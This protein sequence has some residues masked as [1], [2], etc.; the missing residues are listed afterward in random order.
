MANDAGS[1]NDRIRRLQQKITIQ[2]TEVQA[3][4]RALLE[5]LIEL[6]HERDPIR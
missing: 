6:I 5:E 4:S 3:E 2:H 1:R